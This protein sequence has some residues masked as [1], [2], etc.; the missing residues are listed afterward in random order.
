[1]CRHVAAA[2]AGRRPRVPQLTG[3]GASL[4]EPAGCRPRR[5]RPSDTAWRCRS[6][7]GRSRRGTRS[8]NPWWPCRRCG[9]L[10]YERI[11]D[12]ADLPVLLGLPRP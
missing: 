3:P 6:R 5:G 9:R 1:M 12:I 2:G 11:T 7:S 8:T 4:P 10:G